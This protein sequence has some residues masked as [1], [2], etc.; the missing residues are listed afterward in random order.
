[1]KTKIII[2]LILFLATYLTQAQSMEKGKNVFYLGLG[3]GGGGYYS[4]AINKRGAGYSYRRSP[5]FQLGFEHGISDDIPQSVIGIGP[6]LS[7]WFASSSYRDSRGEGWNW[8]WADYTIAAKGFYHHKA[9]MGE[10]WDIY[11]AAILGI[12]YRKHTFSTTDPYYDYVREDYRTVASVFGIGIGGRYYVNQTFGFYAEFDLGYN[13]DYA[14][15]G[16]AFKF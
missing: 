3:P 7:A 6:H 15:I 9:L 2:T 10:N 8:R 1:M 14:Q 4:S 13:A 16:L 11:G 12:R 5:S